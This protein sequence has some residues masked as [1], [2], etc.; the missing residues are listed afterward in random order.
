MPQEKR[1]KH[2]EQ[3]VNTSIALGLVTA[4]ARHLSAAKKPRKAPA[5]CA[6]DRGLRQQQH[7]RAPAG[8]EQVQ[9]L[10]GLLPLQA[11]V[12]EEQVQ[13]LRW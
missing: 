1:R 12:D 3:G 6:S 8:E 13:R 9:R 4:Q 10:R 7:L 5:L 2:K 11:P